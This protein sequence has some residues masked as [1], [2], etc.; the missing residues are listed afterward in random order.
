MSEVTTPEVTIKSA[1]KPKV[2]QPKAND[3][4]A[5]L[6]KV[7]QQIVKLDELRKRQHELIA[8]LLGAGV[9]AAEIHQHSNLSVARI[10]QLKG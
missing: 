3:K 10:R 6:K 8:E 2:E 5:E 1:P 4:L 9:K 7:S